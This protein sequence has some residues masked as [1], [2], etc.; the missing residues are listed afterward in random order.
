[1]PVIHNRGI[2]L[3]GGG[4]FMGRALT[5]RLR[6]RGHDVHILVR[7]TTLDVPD[8][9]TVH[10]GGMENVELLRRLLPRFKTVV[11]LASATTPG[12]SSKSPSL[13]S[14]GNI[15]PTLGLLEELQKFPG[16]RLVYVSSGGTVYGN[17]EHEMVPE[18]AQLSP[19]S[20]YGAGKVAIED[21]VQCFQ[22]LSGNP[23]VILRPSNLYGPGQPRYQGFGVVRT[24]LQHVLDRSTMT[25]WGDGTVVRDFL[26]ID[27]MMSAI[28]CVLDGTDASGTFNVGAGV[29]HSLNDLKN[30]IED[31]CGKRLDIRHEHPRSID[32]Q[33]IVLDSSNME[34]QFG[35]TPLT[36]LWL[37]IAKTW[38]WLCA[39]KKL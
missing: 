27:D 9:V 21:F 30:I 31:V 4:G 38:E 28:E 11:H 6:A 37:G 20:F 24:M 2:L 17:P 25:I 34:K 32:V 14:S 18:S 16:L 23:V 10:G 33:R 26:Y 3:L 36:G 1:M 8:G 35:W 5:A 12:L 7:G 22:R 13:E 29:G 39:Q 15:A 19:L